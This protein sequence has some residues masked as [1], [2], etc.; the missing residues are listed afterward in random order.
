[1]SE[2][3]GGGSGGRISLE[4]SVR[5]PWPHRVPVARGGRGT[6][7]A[8]SDV[9]CPCFPAPPVD[10]GQSQRFAAASSLPGWAE[11]SSHCPL[12]GWALACPGSQDVILLVLVSKLLLLFIGDFTKI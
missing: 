12:S 3:A 8:T 10:Q 6:P 11:C 4:T 2:G 9:P 1:M 7:L 5:V